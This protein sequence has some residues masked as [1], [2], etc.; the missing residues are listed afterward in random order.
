MTEPHVLMVV[1][2]ALLLLAI[3]LMP[4][5]A[6]HWWEHNYHK[7][8]IGLGL[9]V[10]AYYVFVL[11]NPARIVTTA[12]E[13]CGFIALIG[14]LFVIAGSIHIRMTGHSTPTVNTGLLALGALLANLIGTTGAS[15]LL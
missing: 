12:V 6:K 8:S 7:T 2:F 9:I 11:H 10:V 1:P 5:V 15:M 13:Y 4:F 14:S 3:A